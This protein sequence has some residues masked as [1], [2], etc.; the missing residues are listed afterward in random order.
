MN[1]WS[2][3]VVSRGLDIVRRWDITT[4]SWPW[5]CVECTWQSS[6]LTEPTYCQGQP[7]IGTRENTNIHGGLT[8][9]TQADLRVRHTSH[10]R[11]FRLLDSLELPWRVSSL[12]IRR[13]FSPDIVG[14][15]IVRQQER[16]GS[17]DFR[18][19]RSPRVG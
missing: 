17:Y 14:R 7:S 19:G 4:T 12:I 11:S 1:I 5:F 3:Y 16:R 6:D 13:P 9:I 15:S 2:R 8:A 10:G 18:V